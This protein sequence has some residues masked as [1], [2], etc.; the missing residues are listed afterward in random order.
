VS[1]AAGHEARGGRRGRP[2]LRPLARTV[3]LFAAALL[4]ATS[5]APFAVRAEP[6]RDDGWVRLVVLHTNDVHG[7]LLPRSPA[8]AQVE[9]KG[10]VGGFAALASFVGRERAAAAE[11]GEQVLLLDAGDVWRGTPEG[12]LT[13]GDLVVEAFGRLRYDA[14]AFGNHELDLGAENA[15]R[16]ARAA[17]FPWVSASVVEKATGKTPAWL[18]PSVVAERGGVRV[19]VVGLSPPD[20]ARLVSRGE[21]LPLRF[22]PVAE[23]ARAGVASLEGKADVVIF[24]THLGPERD[25]EV[26]ATVPSCPLVVGGHSHTR[27]ARPIV[28][29]PK[30]GSWVVQAGTA[31]VV[32]GRVRLRFRPATKEIALDAYDLVPLAVER[33]GSD[34]ETAA[35]LAE[36]LAAI[37]ELAALSK[38]VG[39]LARDLPRAG[40]TPLETTPA[41]NFVADAMRAAVAGADVAL[42]NRGGI[43]VTLPAGVVTGRDLHL[44]MPFDDAIVERRM[45]GAALRDLLAF[46]IG[47]A[48]ATPL[49]VSGVTGR[50]RVEGAPPSATVTFARLEVGGAPLDPQKTYRVVVNTFLARGGDGYGALAGGDAPASPDLRVREAIRA[51]LA[52]TPETAPD[53]AVRLG[54]E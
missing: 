23:A 50:F 6:A 32:A 43:R 35:F 1:A 46:S 54:P 8:L 49:E 21:S 3:A 22:L 16:L 26:L 11:R 36:R 4:A 28:G 47:G 48:R 24:L 5:L 31:C 41:G 17:K 45:T 51:W 20:T 38:P 10:D 33:V 34:P 19:G 12:D 15:E 13:R 27:I 30:K 29:G 39:R 2:R 42:V 40:A 25:L 14:V 52:R 18:A 44:L 53:A 9:A 7:N 37:P